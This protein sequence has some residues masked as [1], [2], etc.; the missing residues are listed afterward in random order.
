MSLGTAK[1]MSFI[2]GGIA[3]RWQVIPNA[4]IEFIVS[5]ELCGRVPLKQQMEIDIYRQ[6]DVTSNRLIK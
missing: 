2:C 5:N 4:L 1:F 3:V 6:N